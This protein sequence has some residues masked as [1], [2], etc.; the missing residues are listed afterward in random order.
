MLCMKK[1]LVIDGDIHSRN[2]VK[3]IIDDIEREAVVYEAD[4]V[5]DAFGIAMTNSINMFIVDIALKEGRG[6]RDNSGVTFILNIRGVAKY[7]YTPVIVVSSVYDEGMFL[8]A[9]AHIYR[10]IEKPYNPEF[11]KNT[12]NEALEHDM[13]SWR[14]KKVIY[15]VDGLLECIDIDSIIY[16]QS[17]DHVMRIVTT[18]KEYLIPYLTCNKLLKDVDNQN[19]VTC[20]RGCIVNVRYINS[21][22]RVNRYIFLEKCEDKLEIGLKYKKS[23]ITA[24]LDQN[25]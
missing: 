14:P 6:K 11:V 24:F 22:D 8:Y 7:R 15:Q 10:Y 16:A 18:K 13:V 21:I 17:N 12:I 25:N 23:L 1:V 19:F 20:F 3:K 2:T 5:T 9:N 4:N